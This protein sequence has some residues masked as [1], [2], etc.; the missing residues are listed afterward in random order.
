MLLIKG[1]EI[2]NP[3]GSYS[4]KGD[5]LIKEGKIAAIG[6]ELHL[7]GVPVL[8]AGGLLAFPGLIDVH[9]H[10]REPGQEAKETI[11][12]GTRAAARGGFTAVVT[13]PNTSPPVDRAILVEGLRA[14]AE[15][16][17]VVRVY[18]VACIT[19]EQA[20]EE[21]TEMADLAAAGAVAF[22]DDG[23]PVPSAAVM[24][25]ALEYAKMV[26]RPVLSHCEEPTLARGGVMHEGYWSTRLGLKGIP[27][28][29]EEIMVAREIML[30]RETGCPVHLCHLSTAGSVELLRW[31]KARGIPV[32]AE[33]TP[34]HLTLT[35][36]AVAGYDTSTK[37][38]P[39]LRGEEDLTALKQ[40]LAEGI[41]DIIAT[42][43]APHTREEKEQEYDL[44]PFGLVGLE[45][46]LALC[47][48]E[49]VGKGILTPAQLVEKMAVNPARLLGIEGGRL[50]EGAAADLV[51]FDPRRV[52]T[53]TDESLVS[54]GKN[55]PF[56]GWTLTGWP[57]TT[58]VG[59]KL[60][61]QERKLLV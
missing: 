3:A 48:Q 61:M 32:T 21:I 27:A 14:K 55:T 40:A 53:V 35:A 26:G 51:L 20:G 4:G 57:V 42:D 30:A 31:A 25:R 17:G 12:S 13:M 43:H 36:A 49:L 38:N 22:S 1:A 9:V 11:A 52:E 60:V 24:R 59:G 15:R 54:K 18:P 29:A 7:E 50:V 44:A 34:H 41:I 19:K 2:V 37:V 45:T 46:A 23:R 39:P 47:W 8:A 16:E 33:V 58:I 28:A 6:P 10:L 56:L 5:I